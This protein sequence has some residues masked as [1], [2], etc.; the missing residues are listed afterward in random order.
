MLCKPHFTRQWPRPQNKGTFC[1][2]PISP[3]NRDHGFGEF[4]FVAQPQRPDDLASMLPS[5]QRQRLSQKV[6]V[7]KLESRNLHLHNTATLLALC[8]KAAPNTEN[9]CC[10]QAALLACSRQVTSV[11]CLRS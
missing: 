4:E 11:L 9:E 5:R 1:S 7:N 2:F 3:E 10:S 8:R 6:R